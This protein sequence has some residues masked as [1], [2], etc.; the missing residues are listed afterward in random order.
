MHTFADFSGTEVQES[1]QGEA[2]VPEKPPPEISLSIPNLPLTLNIQIQL[3][4]T[5]KVEVYDKI[6]EALRK[7][8]IDRNPESS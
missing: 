1:S 5:E 7:N 4:L 3:P 2:V 8:L 6:F